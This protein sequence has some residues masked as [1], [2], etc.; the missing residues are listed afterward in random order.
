MRWA[1]QVSLIKTT[2]R[3]YA[4]KQ[5]TRR[6]RTAFDL[7]I[8]ID[9]SMHKEFDKASDRV[10]AIVGAAYLDS[11]LEQLL[12]RIFIKDDEQVDRL[13][14]PDR[15]LGSNGS[16]YQLAYC[17]GLID[18]RERDDLSMI[19]KVRNAFAHRYDVAGFNHEEAPHY[20]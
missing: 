11:V 6:E 15:P 16:K 2:W 19:A 14:G 5:K 1:E 10:L 20:L 8:E 18:E 17:L 9:Q 12:R 3:S 13:L 4:K 7:G